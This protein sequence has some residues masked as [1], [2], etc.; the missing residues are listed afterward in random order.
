[1]QTQGTKGKK[2]KQKVKAGKLMK[3]KTIAKAVRNTR[4]KGKKQQYRNKSLSKVYDM[5]QCP[6]TN[7]KYA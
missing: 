1:M 2:K 7:G 5:K 3:S 6:G 4:K